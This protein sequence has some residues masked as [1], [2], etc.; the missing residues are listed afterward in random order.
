LVEDEDGR[1]HFP[2]SIFGSSNDDSEDEETIGGLRLTNIFSSEFTIETASSELQKR[3]TQTWRK[4]MTEK[5]DLTIEEGDFADYTE[6]TFSPD[7][8]TFEVN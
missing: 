2:T 6:V 7:P 4:N 8:S 3:F 1:I 5:S